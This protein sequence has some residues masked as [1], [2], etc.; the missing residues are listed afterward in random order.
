MNVQRK[1]APSPSRWSKWPYWDYTHM[2]THT[3]TVQTLFG[4]GWV[5]LAPKEPSLLQYC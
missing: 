4:S 2:P 5:E 3:H 1:P